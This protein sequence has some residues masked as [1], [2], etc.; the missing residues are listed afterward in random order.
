LL[1]GLVLKASVSWWRT[2]L[3]AAVYLAVLVEVKEGLEAW[4]GD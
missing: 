3:L 4:R 1:I 2:G